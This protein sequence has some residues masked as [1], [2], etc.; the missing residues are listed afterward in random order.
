MKENIIY[1]TTKSYIICTM[2]KSDIGL[3]MCDDPIYVVPLLTDLKELN[4]LIFDSLLK[5]K[6]GLTAPLR[7]EWAEWEK[8]ILKKM[9]EKSFSKLEKFAN[10]CKLSLDS[11]ILKI[12]PYRY[13]EK[14]KGLNTVK[15]DMVEYAYCEDKQYEITLKILEIL[16]RDYKII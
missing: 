14:Y 1:K 5:S 3:Y 2:S 7:N 9:G 15:E 11:S 4:Y 16:D 6:D 10:S 13:I 8:G 12:Y